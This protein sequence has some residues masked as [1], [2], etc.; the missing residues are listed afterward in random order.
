[1]ILT[2]V[3]QNTR[4]PAFPENSLPSYVNLAEKCWAADPNHRPSF[5]ETVLE[6]LSIQESG[7]W[8]LP[9]SRSLWSCAQASP[10]INSN[11]NLFSGRGASELSVDMEG[12]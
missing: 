2:Q 1:M 12:C 9:T 3:T 4:R 6:L 11:N 5:S 7:N 8:V 10:N